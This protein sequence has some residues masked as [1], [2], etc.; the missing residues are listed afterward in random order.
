[1]SEEALDSLSLA[2]VKQRFVDSERALNEIAA[3]LTKLREAEASTIDAAGTLSE[4]STALR[5]FVETSESVVVELAKV[6]EEAR[7]AVSSASSL[8]QGDDIRVLERSVTELRTMLDSR[9]SALESRVDSG[10]AVQCT[11]CGARS[12]IG[13]SPRRSAHPL[14]DEARHVARAP[15]WPVVTESR[16]C[17]AAEGRLSPLPQR[18][19]GRVRASRICR[20]HQFLRSTLCWPSPSS[21]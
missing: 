1:M 4:A 8:L 9:L 3:R 16:T 15:A 14:A 13:E 2:E 7:T 11:S 21:R 17:H 18:D 20:D 12:S 5:R 6:Q 10:G 19:R